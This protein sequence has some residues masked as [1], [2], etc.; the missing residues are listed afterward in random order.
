MKSD[1]YVRVMIYGYFEDS[2][3]SLSLLSCPIDH[4]LL[5]H[6]KCLAN[7]RLNREETVLLFRGRT[8]N[9]L[10]RFHRLESDWKAFRMRSER[11][12]QSRIRTLRIQSADLTLTVPAVVCG[13]EAVIQQ[14]PSGT[15]R[16]QLQNGRYFCV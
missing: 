9:C 6:N 3:P 2:S 8:R 5:E 1:L 4:W 15:K 7:A 11:S 12:G 14:I 16:R 13:K 10:E